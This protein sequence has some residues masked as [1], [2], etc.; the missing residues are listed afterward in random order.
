MKNIVLCSDGTG[1]KGG[2]GE[3]SNVFK[4]YKATKVFDCDQYSFYDQ[5]VGTDKSDNT[6]NKY[7]VAV[8]GAF[9]FG[10]RANVLHLYHFL[11]RT[12]NPGDTIFLFGFSR[13]AATVRAFAGFLNACGLI[14]RHHPNLK[15]SNNFD[16]DLKI[17]VEEAFECY[18]QRLKTPK[19]A[20]DFKEQYAVKDPAH[21]PD[22]NLKIKFVGVWDTVSALG[23]PDEDFSILLRLMGKLAKTVAEIVPGWS[24][25][26]YDY[27]LNN[28]IENAYHALSIDDKRKTFTPLVWNENGYMG[29]VEQVWFAGVHS[30]V[31]GGYPRTGLSDVAL[32]WMLHKAQAQGLLLHPEHLVAIESGMNVYDKLYDSRDGFAIY[33]SYDPRNLATLCQDEKTQQPKLKGKIALHITA[34]NKMKETS[35]SYTPYSLPPVFDVVDIDKEQVTR[36][37]IVKKNV[38]VPDSAR[39]TWNELEASMQKIIQARKLLYTVF[40]ETTM[41]IL[42]VAGWMWVHQPQSVSELNACELNQVQIAQ[43]AKTA[44]AP[45]DIA[46]TPLKVFEQA[47]APTDSETP[48]KFC[49]KANSRPFKPVGDILRYL[50][51][52]YFE[53]FITY[54]VEVQPWIFVAL[55]GALY[56]MNRKSK[57]YIDD[58]N[59][60][61]GK[62]CALL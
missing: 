16:H 30:N 3:D 1:N 37:T 45:S 56:Y 39:Q 55:L 7:W 29:H 47:I 19:M 42:L 28:S 10:F 8:S 4:T 17:L 34:Y 6:K 35:D 53:N 18:R 59:R 11:I 44:L 14:D 24:Y 48:P 13:G 61:C 38:A 50:T 41:I 9:G 33:Y 15:K 43:P 22:G 2:Y 27:D 58:L 26:F 21:A 54:V 62:L 23:F 51:P 52:V 36:P 46:A 25:K 31:G 12:Y 5:G 60:V 32:R 57:Q 49:E 40:V 20:Q